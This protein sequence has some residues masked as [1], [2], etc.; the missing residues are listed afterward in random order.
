MDKME[1][2]RFSLY[3]AIEKGSKKEVLA[4]SRKLD[5]QIVELIKRTANQNIKNRA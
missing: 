1:E 3:K 4:L 2:L 5:E